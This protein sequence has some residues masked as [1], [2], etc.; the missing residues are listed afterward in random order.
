M[1]AYLVVV[2]QTLG[3]TQVREELRRRLEKQPSSFYV[4]VPLRGCPSDSGEGLPVSAQQGGGAG[5]SLPLVAMAT[6]PHGP[7]SGEE[8][9]ALA[10][11]RLGEL[12]GELRQLGA[13]ADGELGHPDPLPA[14]GEVLGSRSFDEVIVSTPPER[15][16]RW[17][18]LDL[19]HRLHRRYGLPVTNVIS[20]A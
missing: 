5:V 14:V 3:G 13:E 12:L 18:G 6:A 20:K 10:Q 11:H 17:L 1:P 19:P 15:G 2:N 9:T 16:A 4:V 7:A 8:A